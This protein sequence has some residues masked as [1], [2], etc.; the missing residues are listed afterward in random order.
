MSNHKDDTEYLLEDLEG[1]EGLDDFDPAAHLTSKE[2][3][4][5]YMTQMLKDGDM[6]LLKEALETLARAEGM[7][8]V[9]EAAGMTREGAYKALKP[10]SKP[11]METFV[12]L[13]GALGMTIQIVP[14]AA[15]DNSHALAA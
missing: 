4:A 10:T 12:K 11:Y 8:T 15:D 9:A 3:A 7:T 13:L 5:A 2:A 14:I 6:T 1:I